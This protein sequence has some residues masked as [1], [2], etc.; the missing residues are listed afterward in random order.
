MSPREPVGEVLT[1][2]VAWTGTGYMTRVELTCGS[3]CSSK[4]R[5]PEGEDFEMYFG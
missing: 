3:P 2:S 4:C 5:A 1:G